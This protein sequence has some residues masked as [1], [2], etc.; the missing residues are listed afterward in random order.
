[1]L[2][3]IIRH[4]TRAPT[5]GGRRTALAREFAYHRGMPM[6]SLIRSTLAT[7]CAAIG[8]A[9][10]LA[11]AQ[12]YKCIDNAGRTTYQQTPC[13]AGQRG[14]RV[15][16]AVDNGSSRDSPDV[17]AQWA[18]AARAGNIVNG[19]PKR[20][21]QQ[22][23]GQPAEIR[24][25]NAD[26]KAGEVWTFTTSRGFFR[27]GFIGGNVVWTRSE[28]DT[29]V[30]PP[31]AGPTEAPVPDQ[32]ARSRVMVGGDCDAV[33]SELG[34]PESQEPTQFQGSLIGGENRLLDG[35]R[36]TYPADGS[37]GNTRLSF[38]CANGRIGVVIRS[39]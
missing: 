10:P 23:L 8:L 29:T 36:Y 28:G 18:A 3:G 14:S 21:V 16:L 12:V 38:S 4:A 39:R 1:M 11:Q 19:M 5:G 37:D 32:S 17:E 27:V 24:A 2:R 20:W 33:L 26:D 30:P 22:A 7:T 6:R 35:I 9:A 13:A 34:A 25:G 31:A 15:D